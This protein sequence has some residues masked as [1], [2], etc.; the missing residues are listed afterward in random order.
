VTLNHSTTYIVI[1]QN[2]STSFNA[3]NIV[4]I[5]SFNYLMYEMW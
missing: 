3:W 1:P 4:L 2:K 5:L